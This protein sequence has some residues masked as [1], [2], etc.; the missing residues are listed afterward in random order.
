MRES[1]K[2]LGGKKKKGVCPVFHAVLN[3]HGLYCRL[4]V[5]VGVITQ[6]QAVGLHFWNACFRRPAFH[7][8]TRK[9]T[10]VNTRPALHGF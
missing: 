6:A 4:G 7:R 10:I 5:V 2:A 1:G 3:T 8:Q 9:R